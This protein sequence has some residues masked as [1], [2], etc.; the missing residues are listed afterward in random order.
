MLFYKKHYVLCIAL[1]GVIVLAGCAIHRPDIHQGQIAEAEDITKVQ[2]GMTKEEVQ[3]ILGTPLLVDTFNPDRWDYVLLIVG[4]PRSE[5]FKE[6]VTIFFDNDGVVKVE[7]VGKAQP[8]E[9][10]TE[11]QTE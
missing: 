6:R 1:A 11:T 9:E 3:S 4:N 7:Q 5:V 2:V 10:G 8:D